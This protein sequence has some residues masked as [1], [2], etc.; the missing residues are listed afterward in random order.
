MLVGVGVGVSD[1][2]GVGV[3]V[4]TSSPDVGVEN[5]E[6]VANVLAVAEALSVRKACVV[7]YAKKEITL[8]ITTD[9]P[10][11]FVFIKILLAKS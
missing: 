1:G 2:V 6:A 7:A 10:I 11:N 9:I 4:G 8:K 5:S 3:L